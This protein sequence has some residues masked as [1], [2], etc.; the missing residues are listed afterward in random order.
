MLPYNAY[1]I[2]QARIQQ[3]LEGDNRERLAD[4]A[5]AGRTHPGRLVKLMSALRHLIG[6]QPESGSRSTAEIAVLPAHE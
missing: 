5:R 1:E 3:M 2:N 6:D 4:I